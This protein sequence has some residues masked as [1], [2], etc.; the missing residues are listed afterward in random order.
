MDFSRKDNIF[1]KSQNKLRKLEE[2]EK[3][4]LILQQRCDILEKENWNI[5]SNVN[6]NNTVDSHYVIMPWV[7]SLTN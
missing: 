6:L 3:Q 1:K 2:V 5:V 7:P 4:L